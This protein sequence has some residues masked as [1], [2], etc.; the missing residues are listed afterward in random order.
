[1]SYIDGSYSLLVGYYVERAGIELNYVDP[2]T[3]D[4]HAS[5]KGIVLLAHHA[6]TTYGNTTMEQAE[7]QPFYCEIERGS[8]LLDPWRYLD[9]VMVNS[10]GCTLVRYGD[11]RICTK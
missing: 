11:T 4:H 3:D 2:L 7:T 9:Q 6:P 10:W 5:I 8:V 1:M